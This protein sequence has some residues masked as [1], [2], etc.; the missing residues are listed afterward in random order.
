MPQAPA[1]VRIAGAC[2]LVLLPQVKRPA[3][4]LP[5]TDDMQVGGGLIWV[6]VAESGS[7]DLR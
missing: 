3:F 2:G 6:M 5:C 7:S 4:A 1:N